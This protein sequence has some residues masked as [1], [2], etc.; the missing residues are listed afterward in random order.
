MV[1]CVFATKAAWVLW[2]PLPRARLLLFLRS[3]LVPP[4]VRVS[5]A[6]PDK[7]LRQRNKQKD[8]GGADC[9]RHLLL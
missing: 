8:E 6:K 1:A 4:Q 2:T 5:P 9:R 3:P 7:T